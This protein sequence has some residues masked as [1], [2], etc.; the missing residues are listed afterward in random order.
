MYDNGK[1][2]YDTMNMYSNIPIQVH[3]DKMNNIFNTDNDI[4]NNFFNDKFINKLQNESNISKN[5]IIKHIIECLKPI[6]Y[7]NK[8]YNLLECK[9]IIKNTLVFRKTYMNNINTQLD[10]IFSETTKDYIKDQLY[11][12]IPTNYEIKNEY[13]DR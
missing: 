11:T 9:T 7:Q 1:N 12:K 8:N 10:F 13:I 6:I 2:I 4:K 5:E 3:N